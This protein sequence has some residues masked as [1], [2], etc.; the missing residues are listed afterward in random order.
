MTRF[1]RATIFIALVT[2]TVCACTE[3]PRSPN[4]V[5]DEFHQA[6]G[7]EDSALALSLLSPDVV[8]FESGEADPTRDAYAVAHLPW[9]MRAARQTERVLLNR[10]DG[11]SGAQRWVLSTYRVTG[12]IDGDSINRTI[13]ETAILREIGGVYRIVHLHWSS[14]PDSPP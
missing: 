11:G 12:R 9:D 4:R 6:L 13:L 3:E 2:L 14:T 8:V 10:Q 7:K 1:K 5:V